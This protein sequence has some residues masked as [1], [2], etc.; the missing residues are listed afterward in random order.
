[1]R[2]LVVGSCGKR[3]LI[4]HES[5]PSCDDLTSKEALFKWQELLCNYVVKA[6]EMYTGYLNQELVKGVD[7]LRQIQGIEV[8]LVIVSAGFGIIGENE[9]IPPYDCSFSRMRKR[10]I[11]TRIND[12]RIEYDFAQLCSSGFDIVYLALGK[13]YLH[14]LG[15]EWMLGAQ[16]V[17]VGFDKTLTGQRV[18]CIPANHRIVSAFSSQGYTIHGVVG[19]KGDLLRILAQF[20]IEHNNPYHEVMSWTNHDHLQNL[21]QRMGGL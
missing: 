11:Q 15:D 20:A 18:V 7:L 8:Q 1:M 6:R 4:Q 12:L 19:F 16:S 21:I 13:N 5:A 3:K 14:A 9:L 10:E 2:I 17:I